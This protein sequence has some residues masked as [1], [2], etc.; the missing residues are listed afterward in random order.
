MWAKKVLTLH[1]RRAWGW[2]GLSV[3]RTP[4]WGRWID[5]SD[6]PSCAERSRLWSHRERHRRD[7]HLEP[8]PQ[9]HS[10]TWLCARRPWR[11]RIRGE[12]LTRSSLCQGWSHFASSHAQV[13]KN[14]QN[15]LWFIRICIEHRKSYLSIFP[16]RG[17]FHCSA[18]TTIAE[19]DLSHR[20]WSPVC[21][22]ASAQQAPEKWPKIQ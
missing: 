8:D 9:F 20:A 5:L 13:K 4:V 2:D 12:I 18:L 11:N 7:E 10:I 14:D 21:E 17:P 19:S 6:S 15:W 1:T 22:D 3:R 16:L